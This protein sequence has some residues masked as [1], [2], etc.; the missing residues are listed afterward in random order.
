MQVN[1][2]PESGDGAAAR[3]AGPYRSSCPLASALDIVG[4]KWTLLV[5]RMLMAGAERFRD[6][7]AMPEG[8]ATNILADRLRRLEC[9]GLITRYSN[10]PRRA[11]AGYRLTRTGAGLLPTMQALAAWGH[12]NIPERWQSPDWFTAARPEDLLDP[13]FPAGR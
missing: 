11:D 9:F 4:D 6:L 5:L 8:I 2:S 3:A 1:L 13:D 7:Q 10:G 12:A